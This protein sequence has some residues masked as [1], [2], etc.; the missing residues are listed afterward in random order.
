[1]ATALQ[2]RKG[3]TVSHSTFT[4]LQ[5]EVTVDT[6][7]NTVVVHNNVT[8]GGYPLALQASTNDFSCGNLV[9]SGNVTAYSDVTT[10]TAIQTISN[11]LTKVESLRGVNYTAIATGEHRI[12]V[13]AQEVE[14]VLPEVVQM[15]DNGLLSVAYGNIVGVLIEAVKEL[16][17]K[18][19]ELENK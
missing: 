2:L 15:N 4:G 16:S 1:M 10:K 9:A 18:V 12:G 11:A 5:G 13:I 19:K 17:A 6:D 7:L 8:A 14:Q 3:S